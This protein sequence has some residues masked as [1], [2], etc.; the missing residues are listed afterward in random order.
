MVVKWDKNAQKRLHEIYDFYYSVAGRKVAMKIVTRIREKVLAL[1]KVPFGSIELTL[2]GEPEEYRYT[3]IKKLHKAIYCIED[4]TIVV[5]DIW[6]CRQDPETLR[7][8]V[9]S[10]KSF[11]DEI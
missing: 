9:I 3:V 10:R 1:E 5:V 4:E 6:D 8:R 7:R 2:E 11:D